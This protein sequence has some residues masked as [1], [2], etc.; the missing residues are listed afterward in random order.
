MSIVIVVGG[1]VG[2]VVAISHIKAF[3]STSQMPP[4]ILQARPPNLPQTSQTYKKTYWFKGVAQSVLRS[5]AQKYV[6]FAISWVVVSNMLVSKTRLELISC[7]EDPGC[8]ERFGRLGGK[9]LSTFLR[10]RTSWPKVMMNKLFST[11]FEYLNLGEDVFGRRIV[12]K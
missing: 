1:D 12:L 7:L 4:H 8:F 5:G 11:N 6:M 10:E 2:L 9:H 3:T